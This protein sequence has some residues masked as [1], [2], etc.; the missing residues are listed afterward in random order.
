MILSSWHAL[1][2]YLIHVFKYNQYYSIHLCQFFLSTA[3][4]SDSS[5][6]K[7]VGTNINFQTIL[8]LC[9]NLLFTKSS[10]SLYAPLKPTSIITKDSNILTILKWF[11]SRYIEKINHFSHIITQ[12]RYYSIVRNIQQ[13]QYITDPQ[14]TNNPSNHNIN[15]EY[16]HTISC[17][18][19]L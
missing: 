2:W 19:I 1:Q 17:V 5:N 9:T 6:L 18:L 12:H 8:S 13:T 10:F 15:T 14:W 3:P 16:H 7:I 11:N 4:N